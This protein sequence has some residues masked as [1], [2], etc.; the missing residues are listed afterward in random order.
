MA[1]ELIDMHSHLPEL[2][3][4][5]FEAQA[6]EIEFKRKNNI[7]TCYSCGSPK[8]WEELLPFMERDEIYATFGVHPWF[9]DR[10][11]A[12]DY[13]DFF[14]KSVAV[15]EIGMDGHYS[16][17]PLSIQKRQLEMQLQIAADLNKP[18]VIHMDACEKET[19][20]IIRDFPGKK[21]IHWFAGEMKELEK[22][23]EMDCC[24]TLGPD[25]EMIMNNVGV[26]GDAARHEVRKQLVQKVPLNRVFVETDGLDAVAWA[27]GVEF[28]PTETLAEVLKGNMSCFAAARGLTFEALAVQMRCNFESFLQ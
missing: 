8:E 28:L 21:L 10:F 5:S 14:R 3:K 22:L 2:E 1:I 23:L 17:A 15:G 24:F 27:K 18:I 6:E 11:N 13:M 20:E 16:K 4:T 19:T 26:I 9:A 7:T 25:T 12:A